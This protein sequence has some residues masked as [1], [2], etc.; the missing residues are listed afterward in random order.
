M[1]N[2]LKKIK[3]LC[4][5]GAFA[6]I[7]FSQLLAQTNDANKSMSFFS[8]QITNQLSQFETSVFEI[9]TNRLRTSNESLVKWAA[10][11]EQLKGTA[12]SLENK[13]GVDRKEMAELWFAVLGVLDKHIDPNFVAPNFFKTNDCYLNLV[14]PRDGP[15]GPVGPSG[16]SP[17]ALKNP[18]ARAEYEE[19]L[20][21]NK[22]HINNVIFQDQL[23]RVDNQ[24]MTSVGR[25]I[26]T[27][28]TSS[29]SDKKELNETVDTAKLSSSRKQ[30]IREIILE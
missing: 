27:S 16:I 6:S 30:K 12:N 23:L 21:R 18:A 15:D 24:V 28:Y 4:L 8:G 11:M 1:C 3:K 20:K 5:T 19:M 10:A 2:L 7:T 25:F 26:R 13:Q 29:E 9:Q 14:P 22:E 17:E